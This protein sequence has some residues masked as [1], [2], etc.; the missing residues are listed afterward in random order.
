MYKLPSSLV[1]VV[2]TV[3]NRENYIA[4]SINSVLQQSYKHWKLHIIDDASNDN[5]AEIIKSYLVDPRI[6]YT[7]LSKNQGAGHAL[8]VALSSIDTPYFITL[9]SDDWLDPEALE[10]LV[11]EMQNQP[12]STSLIYGNMVSWEE[13]GQNLIQLEVKKFKP[14]SDKYDF[15]F[16]PYMPCPRFF[17]TKAVKKVGGIP[18]DIPY[19]GR[20]GEDRCLLLKLIGISNFHWVDKNLYHARRHRNNITTDENIKYFAKV[21]KYMVEKILLQWGDKYVPV[22]CDIYGWIN[23]KELINKN[24]KIL[25][26]PYLYNKE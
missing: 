24:G 12:K 3:Y 18:I 19:H 4:H 6:K 13:T 7:Y 22:F 11:T 26:N 8:N 15:I 2:T 21:I 17:R 1:T 5:T 9:D 25:K 16:Y 14:F 23:V 20:F 10:I